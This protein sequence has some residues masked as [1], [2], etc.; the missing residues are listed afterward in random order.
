MGA[1][2]QEQSWLSYLLRPEQN[3]G[4]STSLAEV[5]ILMDAGHVGLD[6]RVDER[7]R[8]RAASALVATVQSRMARASVARVMKR[9]IDS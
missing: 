2:Q 8:A 6:W 3:P 7:S 4:A 9:A 5:R 1:G